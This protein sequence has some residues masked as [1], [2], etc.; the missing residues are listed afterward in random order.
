LVVE[1]VEVAVVEQQQVEVVQV[2]IELQLV[3]HYLLQL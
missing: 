2:V 3:F 1:A